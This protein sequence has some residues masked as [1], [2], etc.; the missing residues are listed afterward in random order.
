MLAILARG[1]EAVEEPC[2]KHMHRVCE[3][4]EIGDDGRDRRRDLT[5]R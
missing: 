2:Q 1:Q 5:K 4:F 3:K